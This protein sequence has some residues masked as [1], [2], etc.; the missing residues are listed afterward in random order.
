MMKLF[1]IILV[2]TKP[3]CNYVI[4]F[5]INTQKIMIKFLVISYL[6]LLD[7]IQYVIKFHSIWVII[8]VHPLLTLDTK[9]GQHIYFLWLI[10]VVKHFCKF[11]LNLL[12]LFLLI[13]LKKYINR[14]NIK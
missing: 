8:F 14:L 7:N 6:H 5:N 4:K 10:M 9:M 11:V 13:Y 3:I 2:I 1:H 12:K